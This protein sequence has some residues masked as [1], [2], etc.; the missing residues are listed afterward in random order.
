MVLYQHQ[1]YPSSKFFF[2]K[3]IM[4][5]KKLE[6]FML[7]KYLNNLYDS[8]E[9]WTHGIILFFIKSKVYFILLQFY[10]QERDLYSSTLRTL[11]N[12]IIKATCYTNFITSTVKT[13]NMSYL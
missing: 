7:S 5:K 11:F 12:A 9:N 1:Q 8:H 4:I 6:Y 10:K 3:P 13:I 2:T